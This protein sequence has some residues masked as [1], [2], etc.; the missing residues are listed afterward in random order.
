MRTALLFFLF[1]SETAVV[2][3]RNTAALKTNKAP[4]SPPPTT[5]TKAAISKG[6]AAPPAQTKQAA[7]QKRAQEHAPEAADREERKPPSISDKPRTENLIK[8]AETAE[9]AKTTAETS[10]KW[11][12]NVSH[13][14]NMGAAVGSRAVFVNSFRGQYRIFKTRSVATAGAHSLPLGFV[15]DNSAYGLTDISLSA[16]LAPPFPTGF[17]A[18]KWSGGAG[19][20]LPTSHKS[21]LAGKRLSLFASANHTIKKGKAGG[22]SG[23]H[24]IYAGLYKYRSGKSGYRHNPLL[25]SFHSL[26]WSGKYKNLLFSAQGRL[27]FSLTL[28]KKSAGAFPKRLRFQQGGQGAN[29][30]LSYM[31][32]KPEIRLFSQASSNIP[33]ISPVLTGFSFLKL[34]SVSYTFGLHWDI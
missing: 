3:A 28:R 30:T 1:F 16:S 10:K 5:G 24:V 26:N 14:V 13:S 8:P 17:L 19:V 33:F 4:L 31:H 32:P 22:F 11:K 12:L 25:N 29:V 21:R 9:T 2:A 34:R 20:S 23:G 15:S 27:Y 7:G 18:E 6:S